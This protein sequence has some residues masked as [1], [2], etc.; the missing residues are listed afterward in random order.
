MGILFTNDAQAPN[1]AAIGLGDTTVVVQTGLGAL[2]PQPVNPGDYFIVVFEN[3]LVKPIAREF[4]R[5]TGRSGD[6]LT[7]IERGQEG[8]SA[9]AFP[10]LCNVAHRMTAGT[11]GA[12]VDPITLESTGTVQLATTL[13]FDSTFRVTTTNELMVVTSST[14]TVT[15][16]TGTNGVTTSP[17]TIVGAGTVGL[18]PIAAQSF[19]GNG[20]TSEAVPSPMFAGNGVAFENA[21]ATFDPNSVVT[22]NL[23]DS[24]PVT[25]GLTNSNGTL[26]IVASSHHY[27]TAEASISPPLLVGAGKY[28]IELLG[29][30]T[31]TLNPGMTT[32]GIRPVGASPTLGVTCDLASVGIIPSAELASTWW[33]GGNHTLGMAIDTINQQITFTVDGTHWHSSPCPNPM[34]TGAFYIFAHIEGGG[35]AIVD[36]VTLNTAV[37]NF[38]LPTGY[39]SITGGPLL[40]LE[41]IPAFSV[42]GN[43]TAVFAVPAPMSIGGGVALSLIDGV[44]TFS[45]APVG[46]GQLVGNPGTTSLAPVGIVVGANLTLNAGGTL[47]S[48]GGGSGTVTSV[49]AGA[50]LAGG[51]ITGAGT[52]SLGTIA[53]GSLMGNSATASAVPGAIAVGTGVSLSVAGTLS[54]S[55][56][57]SFNTRT[58]AVSLTSADVTGALTFTPIAGNQTITLTGDT[59]GSGTTSISTTTSKIG[60][61]ALSLA[62][63]VTHAGAFAST[64]NVTGITNV[65]FPTTGTLANTA[66]LAT[67]L[68]ISTGALLGNDATAGLANTIAVGA[69]LS[70]ASGT[71]NIAATVASGHTLSGAITLSGG[72]ALAGTFSG[73]HTLSGTVTASGTVN[74]TGV[75]T[76]VTQA[77]TDSST[78]A[79][80]TNFV[81]TSPRVDVQMFPTSGTW[82]KPAWAVGLTNATTK[83]RRIGGGG[84]GGGGGQA[85]AGS[86]SSGGASGG[87]GAVLDDVVLTSSLGSTAT[88]TIGA[89]GTSGTGGTSGAG[90]N[91]GA[92]GS[93]T[94]GALG[95]A[96]G[97]GGGGGGQ[98]GAS[99]GGGASAGLDGVGNSGSGSTPGTASSVAVGSVAGSITAGTTSVF[100]TKNAS[101]SGSSVSAAFDGTGAEAIG[102]SGAGGA[103][104][105]AS[106]TAGGRGAAVVGTA[107]SAGGAAA[108]TGTAPAGA[109]AV[110][111]GIMGNTAGASGGGG[112]S[113]GTG[114]AGGGVAANAYGAAGAGGG[115]GTA[116]GGAGGVGCNGYCI[117]IT[118]G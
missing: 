89:G 41:E 74:V 25:G 78:K 38:A 75:L 106:A 69:D 24:D 81:A 70:L 28:Y 101:G 34:S 91:G 94:F 64:L 87:G 7:G 65:T 2:F 76:A 15:G 14:G 99:S 49:I 90:G 55:G 68:P 117:A 118:E 50:G 31:P 57:V 82:T 23:T 37:F 97:G 71:L 43:A 21:S 61:V 102:G 98:P 79:A 116:A 85:A 100:G 77:L 62:A 22:Q 114:G 17:S 9:Q 29:T 47:S 18:T 26:F 6:M 110:G 59:T 88:V 54:N 30:Q 58:G 48:V 96:F 10:A 12:L 111:T 8:S 3:L 73:N 83:V 27:D 1:V 20:S 95:T 86:T 52:I 92:G 40:G 51:T 35:P 4:V 66:N 56:V 19:L 45:A 113:G 72:G 32:F 33:T 16:V 44:P 46:P 39:Q 53:A 108:S 107:H 11:L 67:A 13:D 93:T 105:S 112:N 103:L 109:N 84:G 115:A 80:T 104:L 63:A 36:D 5:V 42:L 60:G